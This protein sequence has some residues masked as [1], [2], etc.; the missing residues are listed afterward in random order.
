MNKPRK[1]PSDFQTVSLVIPIMILI[2]IYLIVNGHITPGGGFQG[3]AALAAV[4]ITHYLISPH[5]NFNTKQMETIEKVAYA[6]IV[7]VAFIYIIMGLY[8]DYSHHY[9]AYIIVMNFLLGTKVFCGLS[10]IFIEF[11]KEYQ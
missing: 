11:A 1:H 5:Q 10:I 7:A 6:V 3:G 8:V 9:E 4:L 2:G